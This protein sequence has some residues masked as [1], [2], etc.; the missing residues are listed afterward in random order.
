MKGCVCVKRGKANTSCCAMD[1][2][3]WPA[4]FCGP[5]S[6][7]SS[8]FSGIGNYQYP[9]ALDSPSSNNVPEQ[10]LANPT[11]DAGANS[12]PP[13]APPPAKTTR[14]RG[15]KP[16][17]RAASPPISHVEAER[18]RRD[19]LNRRFCDL[20]AAVP[21]VSRLDRSSLLSDAVTYI[22]ELRRR[23]EQLEQ[24]VAE[25]EARRTAAPS[26]SS[27]PSH[28]HHPLLGSSG[29][30]SSIA[31]EARMVGPEAA[32]LRLTTPAAGERH[33]PA[34]LM[35]AL[36]AL[37]LPVQ[38]A[39][40]CRVGGATVQDVVVDVPPSS[41]LRGEGRLRAAVLHGL[42]LQESG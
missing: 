29:Q 4:S 39:C 36:R 28:H 18:L 25:A 6:P 3:V 11:D 20:R 5:P 2:L 31:L 13:P 16:G 1:Q 17:P 19:R 41:G 12:P 23:V 40:V 42:A 27:Q 32:A 7:A 15:R 34:R 35:A 26:Q 22:T 37:D 10:W 21:T 33:A 14:R 8:F 9:S 38:H 24:T 30:E